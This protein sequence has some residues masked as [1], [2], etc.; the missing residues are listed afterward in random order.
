M[1]QH[2]HCSALPR[3]KLPL[4]CGRGRYRAREAGHPG[5]NGT[6]GLHAPP[7]ASAVLTSKMTSTPS[8]LREKGTELIPL[9]VSHDGPA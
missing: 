6:P 2:G 4:S 5:D 8:C 1:R 7:L 9:G 3:K